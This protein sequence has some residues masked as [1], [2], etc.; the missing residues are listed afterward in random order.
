MPGRLYREKEGG[1]WIRCVPLNSRHEQQCLVGKDK[2]TEKRKAN[3]DDCQKMRI[4]QKEKA[5]PQ[6]VFQ[7]LYF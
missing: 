6:R 1:N 2:H 5:E 3:G 7:R 4:N